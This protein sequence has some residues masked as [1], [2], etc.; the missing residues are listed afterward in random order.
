LARP[1][2]IEEGLPFSIREEQSAP[3]AI[4]A[5]AHGNPGPFA[6][7]F[8]TPRTTR[9]SAVTL[10]EIAVFDAKTERFFLHRLSPD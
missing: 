10:N 4:F 6:S 3:A 7:D 2:T 1:R 8:D 9:R 5:I